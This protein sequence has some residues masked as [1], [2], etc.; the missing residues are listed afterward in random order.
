MKEK[1]TIT[2]ADDHV[3]FRQGLMALLKQ[4]N[5]IKVINSVNNG[6]ELIESLKLT[7][8]DIVLM[9]I[10]MPVMNGR[11]TIE[12]L[13]QKYPDQKVIIMSMHFSDVYVYDF[14]KN[15]ANGFLSKNCDIDKLVN[16]INTVYEKGICYD[17]DIAGA[18]ASLIKKQELNSKASIK[19]LSKRELEIIKLICEKKSITE[20]AEILSLS[21]RTIQVHRYNISKKTRTK[22][23]LD[24]VDYA[25]QNLLV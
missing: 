14:I 6:K 23:I 12:K 8:P 10:E 11:V 13:K 4:L 24:L 9:D 2:I 1:I 3:V 15:G 21:P 16:T 20:I 25:R 17:G 5:N 18:M 7:R 19:S 22:S